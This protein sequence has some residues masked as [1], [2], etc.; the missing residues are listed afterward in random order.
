MSPAMR[1]AAMSSI[2]SVI[3]NPIASI[4]SL[5]GSSIGKKS[6]SSTSIPRA[7]I[8]CRALNDASAIASLHPHMRKYVR[9][10]RDSGHSVLSSP[11]LSS[12]RCDGSRVSANRS[13]A[14]SGTTAMH[15]SVWSR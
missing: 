10:N 2:S 4:S 1:S 3:L 13:V 15:A 6:P 9:Q 7:F 12:R 5:L 8:S 11:C 14:S